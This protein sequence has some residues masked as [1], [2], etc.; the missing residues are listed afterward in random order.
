MEIIEVTTEM[1]YK[2]VESLAKTIWN[3][4]Y[5]S[6]IGQQQVDYMLEKFQSCEAVK[7]AVEN[8]GYIYYLIS[9]GKKDFGYMAIQSKENRLFLSK[10]YILKEYRGKGYAKQAFA[11]AEEYAKKLGLA[12]VWLTCN[13]DNISSL[14]VY[15]KL[16][17]SIV[18]K[19]D[20]D[21]GSGYI[22]D[23]FVLEKALV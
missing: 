11:F 13:K 8:D 12:A 17:Y 5:V 21:I 20:A 1:Q 4:H 10:L 7:S 15:E 2:A 16:G 22:M 3:E 14:A 9:D 18:D 19:V 23:D 6:I